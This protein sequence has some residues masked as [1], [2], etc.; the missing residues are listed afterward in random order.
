MEE[1]DGVFG[2]GDGVYGY[3]DGEVVVVVIRGVVYW[4]EVD[5]C[6]EERIVDWL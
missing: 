3:G 1:E 5:G 2:G 4:I 6:I